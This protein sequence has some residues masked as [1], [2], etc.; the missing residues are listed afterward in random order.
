MT[1]HILSMTYGP[2]IAG[3][4]NGTIRQTI[5]VLNPEKPYRAGDKIHI[6]GWS[7]RP[8]RS[9]WS[10]RL[11]VF[12]QPSARFDAYADRVEDVYNAHRR[13]DWDSKTMDHTAQQDG[14]DPPTGL[15]LKA[16]LEGFHGKFTDKPVR[17]HVIRW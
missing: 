3:V 11:T 1:T 16:V 9:S 12:A 6:H 13:H 7:G 5:R 17:F 4:R 2:K 14:I 8:Y 15:A 10:W